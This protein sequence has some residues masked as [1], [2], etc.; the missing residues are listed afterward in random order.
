MSTNAKNDTNEDPE[1]LNGP[2]RFQSVVPKERSVLHRQ[3]LIY[4]I[5]HRNFDVDAKRRYRDKV[6]FAR[7]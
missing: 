2:I 5:V 4:V 6:S 7:A 1:N 3:F